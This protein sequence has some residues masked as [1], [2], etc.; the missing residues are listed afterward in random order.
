MLTVDA[1]SEMMRTC[2]A[3]DLEG[4]QVVEGV[5]R[6]FAFDPAKI[7]ENT[8]Q[9]HILLNELPDPFMLAKGGGWSF[10]M[11][12]NDKHGNQWGEHHNIEELM[13]LGIASG[14]ANYV[15]EDRAMWTHFPGGMP[16]F[17]VKP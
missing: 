4:A 13:C 14:K 9:I 7:Q 11:A 2:L 3:E 10:L 6:S 12:A 8:E 16:Y 15:F 1:V 5:T 17:V